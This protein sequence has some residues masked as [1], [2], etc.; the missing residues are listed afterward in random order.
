MTPALHGLVAA[1]HTPFRADGAP[2]LAVVESQAAHLLACGVGAAFVGGTTGECHSLTL[3]ERLRLAARWLEVTRGTTLEVV[4]HVG[5]NCLAD[6][7]ALAA[8]AEALG[9][10]A[11][12]AMAPSYFKP[13]SVDALVAC[14]ADVAA[15]A[16]GLPF[17]FYDIPAMTGVQ[18]PMP[19]FLARAETR[20]PTLRGL[21][22]TNTDLMAYQ[23]CLNQRDGRFDVL[24]GIDEML[25]GALAAGARGAVGST[26]NFA[27]PLYLRLIAAFRRN[28][29]DAARREQLRSIRLVETISKYGYMAAARATMTMLGVEV[30]PPRLPHLPLSDEDTR[31]LRRDLEALGAETIA[32]RG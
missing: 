27:A 21:K 12:A 23:Q 17:Y 30:G 20:I 29:L 25:I 1:P 4:V 2:G 32:L 26:Y 24:W 28:D 8:Q 19:V 13:A 9:A 14:C 16:P 22:F 31:S 11:I 18:F 15:A 6:A 7:R 3:E 10:R 5:S